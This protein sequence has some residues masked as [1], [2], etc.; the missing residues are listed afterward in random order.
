M[1]IVK[2]AVILLLIVAVFSAAMFG[3]NFHTGP[4]IEANNAGAALAPLLAVMPEG[5]A[6]DGEALIYDAADPAASALAEVGPEVLRVYRE[7]NG[8]GF[9]VQCQTVGNYE[10]TPME[11]TVGIS[12]DGKICGI[13]VDNY[14]DSI[15]VREKDENFLPSFIGMD[16]TLADV[17]IVAGCTFSSSSIKNAVAAGMN[18]LIA[19]GM[20]EEGV[21]S[22]AQ[23]LTEMIPTVHPG[24]ASGQI[25]K[26]TEVEVSGSM[27]T[28][29]QADNN[30][31]FAYIMAVGEENFLAVVNAMGVCKVYDVEGNDVTEAQAALADEAV[32]HAA[33]NQKDMVSAAETKITRMFETATDITP[34]ALDS[35]NTVVY[36]ATFNADGAAYTMFYSRSIGF[37]QMDVFVVID[38]NGAIAKLDATALFFETEYFPV[39]DTVDQPAYKASFAGMTA[40]T[41]TGDNAMI[42]GATMTSDAVKLSTNDAFAAY[43]AIN[44]GGEQ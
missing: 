2:S 24:M 29:Y 16:S 39:D 35:F 41:F 40:E 33:A 28:A 25:L 13:Q 7:A 34:V 18:A 23:I 36:A 20:I 1:K 11:L 44:N 43:A 5:S 38:A 32:A 19:N 22:P 4:L 27:V 30:T 31:G 37:E 12:A 10:A 14:T 9:A 15:D 3:L 21:K 8:A 17:Q 42:A 26:A 6:F